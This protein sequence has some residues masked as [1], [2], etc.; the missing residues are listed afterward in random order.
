MLCHLRMPGSQIHFWAQVTWC[1]S[2]ALEIHEQIMLDIWKCVNVT[3]CIHVESMYTFELSTFQ[4]TFYSVQLWSCWARELIFLNSMQ[5]LSNSHQIVFQF[6]PIFNIRIT[7]EVGKKRTLE[8]IRSLL[9]T[10]Y[11]IFYLA[12]VRSIVASNTPRDVQS[13]KGKTPT[14]S[15]WS[16]ALRWEI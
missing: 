1:Y 15:P 2:R 16:C 5:A 14:S 9:S 12:T 3:E 4:W 8:T 13:L 10:L 7:Y 6:V 11:I